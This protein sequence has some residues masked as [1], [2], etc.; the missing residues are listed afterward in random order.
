MKSLSPQPPFIWPDARII[1][2]VATYEHLPPFD[3]L[4]AASQ[5][6]FGMISA[7]TASGVDILNAW[8]ARD[9][10]FKARLIINVYPTCTT[11]QRDLSKLLQVV[12][13]NSD[14]L[15]VHVH[16]LHRFSD[17]A[18]NSLA[19]I[20]KSSAHVHIMAGVSGNFSLDLQLDVESNFAFRADPA[21]V[22][23]FRR[24]FDWFWS[25]STDLSAEGVT[26]IPNLI[27]PEGT[28]EGARLWQVYAEACSQLMSGPSCADGTTVE[29]AGSPVAEVDTETGDVTIK[30]S[31]GNEVT[32]PTE[33]LGL[34]KLDQLAEQM[35][36]IYEK[37]S[38]VSID[39]LSRIPPLDTPVQPRVFGD[40][41]E[42]IRGGVTRRVAT[43]V[44][45]IDAHTLREIEKRRKS[46]SPLLS[47]FSFALADN[48]RWMPLAARELFES[49]LKRV[50]DEGLK[51]IAD[52]LKGDIDAYLNGRRTSLMANINQVYSELGGSG[53]VSD[54]VINEVVG[55]LKNR[56][57]KAQ[58][59]NF[60]PKLSYSAIVFD[61]K[62]ND[63]ISP[64]GQ[65]YSLLSQVAV[66]PRKV[67][68]DNFFL[69]GLR[70]A[71]EDLIAAMNVADDHVCKNL[72]T[73]GIKRRCE[74]ELEILSR[75]KTV[76]DARQ[77]CEL[78]AKVIAG[79][80][81][82]EVYTKLSEL[83]TLAS[84]QQGQNTAKY[85]TNA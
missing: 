71:E 64:W 85:N 13:D 54:E 17:R 25:K 42:M 55:S 7:I 31:S 40:E 80:S 51:L 83:E 41:A 3:E 61:R 60:M 70:V 65:A 21:F 15:L 68:T 24:Y 48:L 45:A 46:V 5:S 33:E 52:L 12:K 66:F 39:K 63:F 69:R 67:L 20:S 56:L 30:S 28:E 19:L 58:S 26:Q 76:T 78:V 36:R 22:E 32:S 44:S 84:D 57:E 35:A 9:A 14:R 72:H 2:G 73:R 38:L 4:V 16:P 8:L 29:A 82:E 49:E 53:Q 10:D 81:T 47:K 34:G 79:V 74:T 6:M 1:E 75:V 23:S 62:E 11:R 37:G 18:L 77:R 50:N 59:S 27:V 43:R